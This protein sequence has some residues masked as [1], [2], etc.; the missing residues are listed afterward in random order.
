MSD[1]SSPSVLSEAVETQVRE[2]VQHWLSQAV[3]GLNLCPFAKAVVVHER[4]RVRVS[5]T[6][7]TTSLLQTLEEELQWLVATPLEQVETTLLV[8]PFICPDFLDFNDLVGQAQDVL[9]SLGLAGVLQMADFHPR[10]QFAGTA[11]D[12]PGNFTNRAP[13]PILHLLREESIDR[14]VAST[15]DAAS[16]YER[17]IALLEHM[18]RAGWDL[19]GIRTRCPFHHAPEDES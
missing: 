18:G 9:D 15:P 13:Y 6:R 2:D 17:N 14:A 16:I 19:L 11:E 7:D 8:A 1:D 5:A 4:L 12:D 10:Y 3:I